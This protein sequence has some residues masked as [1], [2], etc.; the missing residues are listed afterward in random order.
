MKHRS[1]RHNATRTIKNGKATV[2]VTFPD[3]TTQKCGGA[4]AER[5]EGVVVFIHYHGYWKA[6]LRNS[7]TVAQN[8]A[9]RANTPRTITLTKG[10]ARPH[11][12]ETEGNP[13]FFACPITEA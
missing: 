5:A 8:E 11:T 7:L 2:T 13:D 10:F 3:G 6:G 1:I 4:R 12:Y 9:L